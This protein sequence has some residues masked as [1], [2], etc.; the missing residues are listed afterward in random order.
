M[1]EFEVFDKDGH[2][3]GEIREAGGGSGYECELSKEERER[4]RWEAEQVKKYK[5]VSYIIGFGIAALMWVIP[6]IYVNHFYR[7][8]KTEH[9]IAND[10]AMAILATIIGSLILSGIFRRQPVIRMIFAAI[11]WGN[12]VLVV[13]GLVGAL[14]WIR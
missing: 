12:I 5:A 3:I 4:Q 1:N 13:L 6:T 9:Q 8:G 14:N 10:M 7:G 11:A 2:K